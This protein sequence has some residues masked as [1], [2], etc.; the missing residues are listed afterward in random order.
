MDIEEAA[1]IWQK[2]KEEL[3]K[4]VSESSMTWI[5]PLEPLGFDEENQC[6]TLLTGH[7]IA[8]NFLKKNN[9]D[10]F[11]NAFTKVMGKDVNFDI[12]FDEQLSQKIKKQKEKQAKKEQKEKA[13]EKVFNLAQMQSFSNLNLRYS[14][15]KF[16]VGPN[17]EFAYNVALAVAKNP[18]KKEYN[19]LFIY[20]A[21]G[22]GKTHLMQ[23]IGQYILFKSSLKVKYI[24][25]ETFMNE[26][27]KNTHYSQDTTTLMNKFRQKY[28]NVDV[29]LIDDIQF[30]ESK[31]KTIN[32]FFNTFN[33]LY[34]K[35]KQI[36]IASDRQP[37][38]IPTLPPRL[39]TR[40]EGGLVVELTPP[41]FDTRVAILKKLAESSE[42]KFSDEV[43]ELVAKYFSKNVRELEGA[44]NK[45]SVYS[46]IKDVE[47]D[48]EMA[49]Q[50][51]K[52][53][54]KQKQVTPQNI[55]DVVC[56]NYGVTEED[57]KGPARSQNISNPRQIGVYL[58]RDMLGLSYEDIADML[59]K[60]HTTVMYGYEQTKKKVNLNAEFK[61]QIKK[62]KTEIKKSV[63]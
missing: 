55:L 10:D 60:R 44:F 50:I 15:E 52:L 9:Y 36:V 3:E 40:F 6:F 24:T 19:P 53:D 46:T 12:T 51:L 32:E 18:A 62:L 56:E 27:I 28:R 54:E 26:Y 2:V 1:E 22:L 17:S 57:L 43:L 63:D 31:E 61:Q 48:V 20:G 13:E 8:A 45:L 7:S 30:L 37:K 16:V 59:N 58:I 38:D 41:D 25:T 34:D 23:A 33:A 11:K 42:T 5:E 21:S 4:N 47:P 49:R 39:S 14:F 29:L 35:G